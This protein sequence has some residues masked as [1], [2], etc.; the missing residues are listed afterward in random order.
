[1]CKDPHPVSNSLHLKILHI[2]LDDIADIDDIT[3]YI[4]QILTFISTALASSAS[5]LVHCA[6]G[7]NRSVA[8]I[9]AYLCHVRKVDS[10]TALKF[11]KTKKEDV[12]PSALLLGQ[13]DRFFGREGGKEDP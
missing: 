7:L 9:L 13:I 12:K 8:A 4:P 11:L 2:P 10:A 1:M 5:I 3:P 6:L